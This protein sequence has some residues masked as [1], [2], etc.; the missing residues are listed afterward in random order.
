MNEEMKQ[1]LKDQISQ[2]PDWFDLPDTNEHLRN[3][4]PSKRRF[5]NPDPLE[6]PDDYWEE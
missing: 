2:C 1:D 4:F 5:R 6:T 3:E